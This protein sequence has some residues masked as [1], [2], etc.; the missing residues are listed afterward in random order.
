LPLKALEE[1]PTSY[2]Q[3]LFS[4]AGLIRAVFSGPTAMLVADLPFALLF[5][6][7]II[8][9]A[10]PI[11][12]V[13][14]AIIPL[15][16]TLTY[17]SSRSQD[18][19]TAKERRKDLTRDTML[20]EL[21]T[22]RTT[23]KALMIDKAVRPQWEDL[24]AH[25]IEESYARGTRTDTFIALGHTLAVMT[26]V[27][28]VAVGALAIIDREMTVGALVATNMLSSRIIAP[29][30]QLLAQWKTFAAFRQAIH[31]L[32]RAFHSESERESAAVQRPRPKGKI[33]F[34][35]LGFH[36][37]EDRPTL[38]DITYDIQPGE[39]VG[40]VGRNG[41]GKTTL[42][43]LVQ[44]LY[45]PSS[46]RV[47][48]DDADIKQFTR[49]ELSRWIGY[50]PQECYLFSGS[51]RDNIAKACPEA[52]DEDIIKAAKASD[53]DFF[54]SD[55]PD[56]YATEIGES[57]SRLSG[58]QRQRIAIARALIK[59]P[60]ILV[61]DEISSNLDAQA[62]RALADHIIT[63]GKTHTIILAT[64]SMQLLNICHKIIVLDKGRIAIAGP[65]AQVIDRITG[66]MPQ[67]P[68]PEKVIAQKP[69]APLTGS[70]N[71]IPPKK[72][73]W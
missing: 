41:G 73:G 7:V 52:T 67:P 44:G 5:L 28:L 3:S 62:E 51:I 58:G 10:T 8:I 4:D 59:D 30:N 49:D 61:F 63:L 42:I 2:W 68:Q 36:Y 27:S 1:K 11:S 25:S 9:I 72:E 71:P 32:D 65:R 26:S 13:F 57:G 53:A 16:L 47:L 24:H 50:V 39:I 66:R 69:A 19:A 14:L 31:R 15:F 6:L 45:T 35:K 34:E 55:M 56:G 43:K 33:S 40:L 38:E 54:I 20:T 21:L 70:A 46:G 23:V 17:L 60:P 37:R 22:G 64:H 29:L 12:W 48:I 18:V